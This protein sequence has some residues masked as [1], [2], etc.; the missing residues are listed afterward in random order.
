MSEQ[1]ELDL[2]EKKMWSSKDVWKLVSSVAVGV[3]IITMIYAR[4]LSLENNLKTLEVLHT[5]DIKHQ[6]TVH[7]AEMSAVRELFESKLK[8]IEDRQT[9]QHARQDDDIKVLQNFSH[10]VG[11]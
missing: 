4:F 2:V 11:R 1:E 5:S 6:E 8:V 3:F 7:Q 9:K 10:P